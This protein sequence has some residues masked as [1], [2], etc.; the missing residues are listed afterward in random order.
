MPVYYGGFVGGPHAGGYMLVSNGCAPT[1]GG[2]ASPAAPYCGPPCEPN[3][4]YISLS[5]LGTACTTVALWTHHK[6]PWWCGGSFKV[7]RCYRLIS[8]EQSCL[9]ENVQFAV[10]LTVLAVLAGVSALGFLV[11]VPCTD[12]AVLFHLVRGSANSVQHDRE[13]HLPAR[14]DG[15]S[16][17]H[18]TTPLWH[19]RSPRAGYDG[20][21]CRSRDDATVVGQPF[22]TGR[23]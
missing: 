3:S 8:Y 20:L 11:D 4:A 5:L 14:C 15:L 17:A 19:S 16:V 1:T 12:P 2:C 18:G 10:S 7:K 13:S 9:R 21:W 23:L 6:Y 22:S